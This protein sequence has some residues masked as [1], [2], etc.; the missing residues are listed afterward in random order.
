MMAHD[1]DLFVI[2]AG[3]GGVRAARMSALYGAK[4]AIAEE[5]RIGGTCVVRGCVPK[6]LYVYASQFA[7]S[8]EDAVGFGWDKVEPRFD[9]PTLV[10]NKER[11][12]SRLSAI[13]QQNLGIS[14]VEVI[15]DRAVITGPHS[16]RLEKSRREISARVILIATGGRPNRHKDL[17]G[18]E[19]AITSE[20]AFDLPKLP[21]RI[22]VAGAGYIGVEFAGIF[23]GL[24]AD[25]TILYRGQEILSGFD[26][27][28]RTSLHTEYERQGIKIRCCEVFKKLERRGDC[29]VATTSGGDEI[30]ADQVMLALG[31]IPNT[32][33]LGLDSVGIPLGKKGEI[34]VDS[35]SKTSVDSIYAIGDVTDRMAL[36]PVAIREGVAFAET[37]F[38]NNPTVVDYDT[39]PTAVF[40]QPEIGTVGM[41]EEAACRRFS[42]VD[43]YETKFRPMKGTLSGREERTMMKLVVDAE[44]QRVVGCHILGPD[45]GEMVQLLGIAIKMKATKA[46]FDATVAVHPTAAEELV[47]MKVKRVRQAHAAE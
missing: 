47:T 20:E 27:D 21:A 12:I 32:D 17:P 26:D 16:V 11:E 9:W 46:D 44:S 29:I 38:N 8:F 23:N 25:T 45:A 18:H 15:E 34:E 33:G 28:L 14:G 41:S 22:I 5:S 4:V 3:S 37:L 7:K 24:G 35:H 31:R 2:G 13:Y 40:S 30:Q 42:D 10:A 39:V 43:V 1:Y 6:K 19:L 36:T